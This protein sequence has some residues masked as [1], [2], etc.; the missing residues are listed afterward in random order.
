[1]DFI[2]SYNI[3]I[4]EFLIKNKKILSYYSNKVKSKIKFHD[5]INIECIN[6]CNQKGG[7]FSVEGLEKLKETIANN[8]TYHKK[9]RILINKIK[10][11]EEQIDKL[12]NA[13]QETYNIAKDYSIEGEKFK[14]LKDDI[15]NLFKHVNQI[16]SQ[17]SNPFYNPDKPYEI[18][19]NSNSAKRSWNNII[20]IYESFIN[21]DKQLEQLKKASGNSDKIYKIIKFEID[22]RLKNLIIF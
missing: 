13:I 1:M 22:K 15:N 20:T 9:H 5:V 14:K 17:I 18:L 2:N 12:L 21:Y 7:N 4:R 16:V 11:M 6:K 19:D 3:L 10:K 8:V